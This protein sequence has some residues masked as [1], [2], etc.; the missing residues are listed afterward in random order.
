MADQKYTNLAQSILGANYTSGDS[1]LTVATGDGA[2][3][4]SS[5]DFTIALDAPPAFFLKCTSRS[6]DVLTVTT[7]GQEGTAT[8]SKASGV[9]VSQVITA[10]VLDLIRSNMVT[11][12]TYANLPSAGNKRAGDSFIC[13]DAPYEFSHNGSIWVPRIPGQGPVTI[14]DTSLFSWDNQGSVVSESS[15]HG[16][17][18]LVANNGDGATSVIRGRVA[19]LSSTTFTYTVLMAPFMTGV[20]YNSCGIYLDDGTKKFYFCVR[21]ETVAGFSGLTY[22]PYNTYNGANRWDVNTWV[23]FCK[24]VWMRIQQDGTN[25][26]FQYSSTGF[27][28]YTLA[29]HGQTTFLTPSKVGYGARPQHASS[30]CE[31]SML[32]LS[33]TYP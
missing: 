10:G 12:D 7:S 9:R 25:R 30:P 28:W 1:T 26:F 15:T 19:T 31:Q 32:S 8:A 14:P 22:N 29:T 11:R 4:P 3:F 5:G 33:I 21:F 23:D 17:I 24:P 6:G 18:H 2:L 27:T 20:N 13:T 16:F